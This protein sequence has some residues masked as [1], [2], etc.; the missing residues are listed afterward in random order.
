MKKYRN[1]VSA[2]FAAGNYQ[3]V[4]FLDGWKTTF[5]PVS[6]RVHPWF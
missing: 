6:I 4:R 5:L 1:G 2:R 3:T